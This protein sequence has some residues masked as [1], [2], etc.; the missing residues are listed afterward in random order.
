MPRHVII[1]R[2]PLIA[3]EAVDQF[4][5]AASQVERSYVADMDLGSMF[6][7]LGTADL[8]ATERYYHYRDFLG[9]NLGK[10]QQ[11]RLLDILKRLPAEVTLVCSQVLTYDKRADENRILKG[12]LYKTWTTGVKSVD[13]RGTGE[14]AQAIPWVINRARQKY[15]LTLQKSQAQRLLLACQEKPS[16]ADTELRKLWMF[17]EGDQ[18]QPIGD[19]LLQ[20]V[21]SANPGARFYELVDAIL[22]RSP[23]WQSQVAQWYAIEADTHR[24]VNELKRRLLGLL[25]LQRGISIQPPF[26]AQ[27]LQRCARQWPPQRLSAAIKCLAELEHALK[28]GRT[29]GATAKDGEFSALQLLLVD[30]LA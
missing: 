27:Q 12:Q 18:L 30:I 1:A 13:L 19:Q 9:L 6:S 22:A 4:L 2:D 29:T 24:L 5:P 8:F 17:K 28:S 25:D 23:H 11:E 26:L 7:Q 15:Q 21:L 16:L 14:G 3:H 20:S 10:K